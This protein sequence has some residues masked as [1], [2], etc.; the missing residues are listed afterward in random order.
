[1]LS[2]ETE[3]VAV[4][5]RPQEDD[6]EQMRNNFLQSIGGQSYVYCRSCDVPLIVHARTPD[7]GERNNDG[8]EGRNS[9]TCCYNH[10]T[11]CTK[12]ISHCCPNQNCL[13]CVCTKHIKHATN[14]AKK[15]REQRIHLPIFLLPD[16]R[17]GVTGTVENHNREEAFDEEASDVEDYANNIHENSSADGT[18]S[19][20]ESVTDTVISAVEMMES[21]EYVGTFNANRAYEA[22]LA[23]Q[24]VEVPP[25]YAEDEV[26]VAS[27]DSSNV[28]LDLEDHGEYFGLSTTASLWK[29]MDCKFKNKVTSVSGAV[30]LNNCGTLLARGFKKL[31]ASNWQANFLQRVVA[32]IPGKSIPLLYMEGSLFPTIFW[33]DD[34]NCSILGAIPTA[35]LASDQTLSGYGIGSVTTHLRNRIKTGGDSLCC[36]NQDY[37][38]YVYDCIANLSCRGEDTRLVLR[39]GGMTEPSLKKE[40]KNLMFDSDSIESRPHVN[41]LCAKMRQSGATYF[42]SHSANQRDH[43]GLK[44]IKRWIDSDELYSITLTELQARKLTITH[45]LEDDVKRAIMESSTIVM[46]RHWQETTELYM[47]YICR[48]PERPLGKVLNAW[49]RHEY[50]ESAGNL[51]HLH[52]LLWIDTSEEEL[53]TT[54]ERIRGSSFSFMT[55]DELDE[56]KAD[57]LNINDSNYSHIQELA[58]QFLT[59]TCSKR[60]MKRKGANGDLRCRVSNNGLESPKPFDH[61]IVDVNV[62]H[63]EAASEILTSIGLMERSETQGF[64]PI[65]PALQGHK[66][67]PPSRAADGKFSPCN[68]RLFAATKSNQ[69]LIYV[70]GWFAARYVA[71]YSAKIDESNRVYVGAG[72]EEANSIK[73]DLHFLHNTKITGSKINEEKGLAKRRDKH[74]PTGRA[75]SIME[76]MQATL[77]Y[78]M[79]HTDINF[80]YLT[81]RALGERAG[82]KMRSRATHGSFPQDLNSTDYIATYVIRNH[83]EEF[84]RRAQE[85][86]KLAPSETI[87]LRDMAFSDVTID[88]ISIFGIRPPE[89]RFVRH[90]EL[91]YKWFHREP[92]PVLEG[93]LR[94]QLE[95]LRRG[96]IH[97]NVAESAWVDGLGHQIFVRPK[98]IA[99]ILEYLHGMINDGKFYCGDHN[100][101]P[102][103]GVTARDSM[104]RLFETLQQW[105]NDNEADRHEVHVNDGL[106]QRY[107]GPCM[108]RNAPRQLTELPIVWYDPI[109]PT[110]GHCFVIHLLLSM[111]SFDNE[112]NLFTH[113]TMRQCFE[114]AD[115]ISKGIEDEETLQE[116]CSIL[117]RKY[118][119]NQLLFQ[120]CG[121]KQFDRYLV[122]AL[123]VIKDVV[124]HN[125]LPFREMPSFLY[126]RLSQAIEET[127]TKLSEDTKKKITE[128]VLDN[129]SKKGIHVNITVNEL[130]RAD[131][132]NPASTINYS[133][134]QGG[135]QSEASFE[136]Q[137]EIFELGKDRMLRYMSAQTRTTKG[138]IING[139]PGTGKTTLMEVL[140]VY[141]LSLGLHVVLS[142]VMAERSTELGG[143]H[144]S[145]LMCIPVKKGIAYG[146]LAELSY[147]DLLKNQ[148]RLSLLRK[149]DVLFIDEFGFVS[150]ELLS[151]MDMIMRRARNSSQFMGGVLIITT[152]DYM[153][154]APVEGHPPLM[155]PYILTSFM[156]RQLKHSVRAGKDPDLQRIQQYTRLAPREFK[157]VRDLFISDIMRYCTFVSDFDDVRILPSTL[158]MFGKKNAAAKATE[159]LLNQMKRKHGEAMISCEANDQESSVEGVFVAASQATSRYLTSQVKEPSTLWFYPGALYEIT[160]NKKNAFNQSQLA[161]LINVPD[162]TQIEERKSI[163]VVVAPPGCK[164]L[165]QDLESLDELTERHG[166]KPMKIGICADRIH[167]FRNGIQAKRL[168]YG[169]KPRVA[170]TIHSG[171]GQDLPSIVTRVTSQQEDNDYALWLREQV[172][173]LLSRTHYAKDILFVGDP[174]KT[175]TAIADCLQHVSQYTDCMT[176]IMN[177]MSNAGTNGGSNLLDPYT[178]NPFRIC[179]F[180][181]PHTAFSFCYILISLGD[182]TKSTTYIGE[183]DNLARRLAVHNQ[184]NGAETTRDIALIPWALLGFVTGFEGEG[185]PERQVFEHRW[186]ARRDQR[187]LELRRK[188]SPNE[189]ASLAV[190]L[191]GNHSEYAWQLIYVKCG[192]V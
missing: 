87:I 155:S 45:F 3:I 79:V 30:V 13:V 131:I 56:M 181:I 113:A 33:K 59:H 32:T 116:E 164:S 179:D 89:L 143:T 192:T 175:A 14:D 156:L 77:G 27:D 80:C 70:T 125:E 38:C 170:S 171:M 119:E 114:Y 189:I 91:Y 99:Q 48:S 121:T 40:D 55:Q 41:Q 172:I 28:M 169:L 178:Y 47:R 24:F 83:D 35:L 29:P 71:K 134:T 97:W 117:L 182:P 94:E 109:A 39:R 151:T 102:N 4:Y 111:G 43:F 88:K 26:S 64:V 153:Q 75:I 10:V 19:E 167:T 69:N 42:G 127:A 105:S 81:T 161:V 138:L 106:F 74:H 53:S 11:Q 18:D 149:L 93:N 176:H 132:A 57:G 162:N 103:I 96:L 37:L 23:E 54:L 67:Y 168:Q 124:I 9:L 146:R 20:V 44:S 16:T 51:S 173:V 61:V 85:W 52:Y 136:E 188:L 78:D 63:T 133:M 129:L 130:L 36:E 163:E 82:F 140:I 115:L 107:F 152:Y 31:T 104:I 180:R 126:T 25:Y 159:K 100:M 72:Q 158:R 177:T 166:W 58:E 184:R 65:T 122:A 118:V 137:S 12:R 139:G 183:T 186:K 165:P 128:T 1:M 15:N 95:Q 157:E 49:Y 98:A 191:I 145:Q 150:A 108:K 6:M 86:Q 62:D 160:Y 120:P 76:M 90:A 50:Q 190:T 2:V 174:L 66:H 141:A 21:A 123:T 34:Q 101:P 144:L 185:R 60:C 22:C 7:A 187:Q 92:T 135:D 8:V 110:Q 73:L 17:T 5:V 112:M 154:L 68:Y 148:D 142:A 46:L 84:S 147:V